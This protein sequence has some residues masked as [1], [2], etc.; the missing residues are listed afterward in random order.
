MWQDTGMELEGTGWLEIVLIIRT[1]AGGGE[2][3]HALG[4]RDGSKP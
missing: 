4:K 3:G 1:R 2:G